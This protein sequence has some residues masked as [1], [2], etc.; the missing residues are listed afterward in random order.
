L[1]QDYR[2]CQKAYGK[3]RAELFM[4]RLGDLHDAQ[5]L[6]DVRNLPVIITNLLV[7]VR[8]SGRVTWINHIG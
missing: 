6:E 2:K 8:E 5:T 3:F 7:I 1:A 4:R